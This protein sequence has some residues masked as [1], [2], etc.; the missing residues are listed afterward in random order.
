M[1]CTAVCKN[2]NIAETVI[3]QYCVIF[4]IVNVFLILNLDTSQAARQGL[5]VLMATAEIMLKHETSTTYQSHIYDQLSLN[6]DRVITSRVLAT[7]PSLVKIVSAVAPPRGGE[8]YGL[9]AFYFYYFCFYIPWHTATRE[10]TREP[11][12]THNSSKDAD[13]LKEVPFKQ[14]FFVFRYFHFLG[15]IFP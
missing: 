14:V 2:I 5:A 8:I 9:R 13:W 7:L 1:T 3:C 15:V 11:I 10:P 4:L 12:L 6:F